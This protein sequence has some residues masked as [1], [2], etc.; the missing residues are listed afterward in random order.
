M[1][2]E[3]G[4]KIIVE[5]KFPDNDIETDENKRNVKLVFYDKIYKN[6][7]AK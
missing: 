6:P 5:D 2:K 3:I 4:F 7:H 1:K